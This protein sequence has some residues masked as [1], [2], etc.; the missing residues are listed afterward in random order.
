MKRVCFLLQVRPDRLAEYRQRHKEVWP[1]MRKAL[2]DTG[3]TNYS[4]F[5]GEDGLLVG[6]VET[7]DFHAALAAMEKLEI[8]ARWQDEMAGFFLNPPG[9]RP[10]QAMVPLEE[11][12][13]LD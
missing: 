9:L 1:E 3:W 13:H 12:F 7:P 11:V 6:Y 2:Q 8:N 5:L 4:L 10:D